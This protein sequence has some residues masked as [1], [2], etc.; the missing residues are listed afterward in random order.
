M[1]KKRFYFFVN[2]QNAEIN[3]FWIKPR[4]QRRSDRIAKI[5]AKTEKQLEADVKADE[6]K[7]EAFRITAR[8][9]IIETSKATETT[10]WN[11]MFQVDPIN[12]FNELRKLEDT[13]KD[14]EGGHDSKAGVLGQRK[15][16]RGEIQHSAELVEVELRIARE[17]SAIFLTLA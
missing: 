1:L 9:E 2:C 13:S 3:F 14:L 4:E 12:A 6:A 11:K 7:E 10:R 15:R 16:S 17:A 5:P 8:S